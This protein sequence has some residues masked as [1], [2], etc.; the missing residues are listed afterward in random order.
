M[1]AQLAC[2]RQDAPLGRV[3]DQ[4]HAVLGEPEPERRRAAGVLAE[5]G[6]VLEYL[7]RRG[8]G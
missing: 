1:T 3:L 5:V 4:A 6:L 8:M 2:A 7:V